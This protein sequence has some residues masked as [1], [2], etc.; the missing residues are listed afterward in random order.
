[1][2]ENPNSP[3]LRKKTS[4][5]SPAAPRLSFS[6]SQRAGTGHRYRAPGYSGAASIDTITALLSS[7]APSWNA[8]VLATCCLR[9]IESGLRH[10]VGRLAL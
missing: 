2:I 8:I 5:H 6:R 9:D 3:A 4:G 7:E 1:M 10:I